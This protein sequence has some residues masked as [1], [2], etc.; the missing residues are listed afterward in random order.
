MAAFKQLPSIG[1]LLFTI[2][3]LVNIRT[4]LTTEVVV[5]F[6]LVSKV[7]VSAQIKG[8]I[9]N[10]NFQGMHADQ[11]S[12]QYFTWF[13]F[14][15]YHTYFKK[16]KLLLLN[17]YIT[18]FKILIKYFYFR[19]QYLNNYLDIKFRCFRLI[20]KLIL[21]DGLEAIGINFK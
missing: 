2:L 1:D 19:F 20:S 11:T 7:S 9:L 16:I 21:K 12:Y 14:M 13:S 6:L 4:N 10:A 5:S 8:R 17:F 15:L 18:N 3:S